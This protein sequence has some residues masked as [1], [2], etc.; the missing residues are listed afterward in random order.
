MQE[1]IS[2]IVAKNIS[3]SALT[4]QEQAL[5]D[6]WLLV[7]ANAD[8]YA[9]LVRV[10]TI[11]GKVGYTM[12][13]DVDAEW[14]QFKQLTQ[15]HRVIRPHFAWVA[16]IAA[17]VALLV[18]IF[19]FRSANQADIVKYAS[20]DT[21]KMIVLPDSSL[22]WLNKNS[23]I[24]YQYNKQKHSRN[25]ALVGEA[26]FK[27]RHNGDDF[28]VKTPQHIFTKVLGTSFNLK[29]Y[30][31][32]KNVDLAVVEGKVS[33]GSRHKSTIVTKGQQASFDCK[34]RDLVPVDSLDSNA[35]AWHSGL[36]SFDNKPLSQISAQLG[37]YLNKKIVLPKDTRNIQYTGKFDHPTAESVAEI[38]AT[39]M[40]WNYQIT[41][42]E[43][44]FSKR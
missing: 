28:V 42:D 8:E 40:S 44:V 43:I 20:A 4:E 35:I 25:V 3:G 27:V 7:P 22:V 34:K 19:T 41:S 21:E 39:A 15:K 1:A 24:A 10:W 13:V 36:F 17:S 5:L 6:E 11:T 38:V 2:E 30:A 37:N 14:E 26:M 32:A 33:F 23:Q 31:D 9:E 29:A 12:H 18:G 16:S